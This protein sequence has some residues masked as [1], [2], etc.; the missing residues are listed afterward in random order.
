VRKIRA[1]LFVL[2][3]SSFLQ[4]SAFPQGSLTPPGPPGSTMLTLDQLGAKADQIDAKTEKRIPI[5]AIHTP[6]NPNT[7]NQFAITQPGSYYLPQNYNIA[8]PESNIVIG[9]DNVTIDLNGFTLSC[10]GSNPDPA[11]KIFGNT[12]I[13]I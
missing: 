6:G 5:D 10:T 9:A 8:F 11:I 2:L 7:P 12:N 13:V 3:S 4:P 1:G